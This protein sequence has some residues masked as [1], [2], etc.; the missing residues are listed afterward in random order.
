MHKILMIEDDTA[1]RD[2][3][4]RHLSRWGYQVRAAKNFQ[5]ILEQLEAF[6]PHLV[7]L[8]I[9]LPFFDGYYWCRQIRRC[10]PGARR[11]GT[12]WRG[13]PARRRG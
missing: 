4:E 2:A 13:C 12:T 6:H 8:D 7:L 11:R 1:T 5:N 9:S 3:L 10:G